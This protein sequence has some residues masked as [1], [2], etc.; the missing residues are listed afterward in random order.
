MIKTGKTSKT[1][2]TEDK[3]KGLELIEVK[4]YYWA[5]YYQS[6]GLYLVLN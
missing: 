1:I 3:T 5:F 6:S 2:R 4:L